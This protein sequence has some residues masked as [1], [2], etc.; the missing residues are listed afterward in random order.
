[1]VRR[2][3]GVAAVQEPARARSGVPQRRADRRISA[4]LRE[5]LRCPR[6]DRLAGAAAPHRQHRVRRSGRRP[7]SHPR[8]LH[9]VAH[10]R[11]HSRRPRYRLDELRARADRRA[12]RRDRPVSRSRFLDVHLPAAVRTDALSLDRRRDRAA[13]VHRRDAVRGHTEPARRAR[14]ALR[15]RVRA[16]PLGRPRRHRPRARGLELSSRNAVA[17][18]PR[19]RRRWRLLGVRSSRRRAAPYRPVPRLARRLGR[20]VLGRMARVSSRDIRHRL[21]HDPRG[22][23]RANDAPAARPRDLRRRGG[24]A[25]RTPLPHDAHAVHA[26]S[27]RHRRDRQRRL[28]AHRAARA[29]Q[30]RFR[31]LVVGSRSAAP[32]S[33]CRTPLARQCRLLLDRRAGRTRRDGRPARQ[34]HRGR[35]RGRLDRIG[36]PP[37]PPPPPGPPPPGPHRQPMRPPP[38]SAGT[39]CRASPRCRRRRTT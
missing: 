29:E 28:R 16:P 38:T 10:P 25:P 8:G 17:P 34:R 27:L 39:H 19:L 22:A 36:P 14:Q 5:S 35:G 23:R 21:G 3:G 4:C 9:Y 26:A 12:V 1:V 24:P 7:F 20:R 11:R 18:R 6:V 33:R 37:P 30:P 2:D 13:R 15:L 32:H 31:R